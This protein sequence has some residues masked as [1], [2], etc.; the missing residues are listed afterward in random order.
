MSSLLLTSKYYDTLYVRYK[1]YKVSLLRHYVRDTHGAHVPMFAHLSRQLIISVCVK[2]QYIHRLS[3][4][5][6]EYYVVTINSN[7]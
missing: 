2:K 6:G 1:C 4:S 7:Y 5:V 3:S